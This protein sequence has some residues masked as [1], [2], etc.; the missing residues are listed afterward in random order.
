MVVIEGMV[1]EVTKDREEVA[2]VALMDLE[3]Q[4]E[5]VTLKGEVFEIKEGM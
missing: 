3:V 5:V 4:L 2:E 1:L